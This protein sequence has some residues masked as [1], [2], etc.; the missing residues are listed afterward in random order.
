MPATA[1]DLVIEQGKTF[2]RVVRWETTPAVYKAITAI[3]QSAPVTLTVPGHGIPDGWKAAVIDVKGMVEVNALSS[4]P[5]SKDFRRV[6]VVDADTVQFNEI[7][8]ASFKPYR[9][10]GYLV[11]FTP[12][13]LTGFTARMTIKDRIGGAV[14]AA[15]TTEN[16]GI[17][18]DTS[19]KTISL[20]I[21][22]TATAGYT[23]TKGV[24]DLELISAT[25]VVTAL[26]AGA[27]TLTKEV[28]T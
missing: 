19:A 7:S 25:G 24:Y 18:V 9:S 17:S 21:S 12:V 5:S 28:T 20:L 27:I 1:E 26:L 6:T 14:L 23:W 22:A 8:A 3:P 10:G 13:T 16:G 2:Q 11:Y 15:L 4:P